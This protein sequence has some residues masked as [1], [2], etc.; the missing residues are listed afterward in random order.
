MAGRDISVTQDALGT[1]RV[2]KTTGMMGEV[3]GLASALCKKHNVMPRSIY[4]NYLKELKNY[5]IS[6]VPA[7]GDSLINVPLIEPVTTIHKL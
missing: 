3:V 7:A 5:I 2:M 6:G 1:V 4:S